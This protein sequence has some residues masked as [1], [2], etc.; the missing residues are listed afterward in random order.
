MVSIFWMPV[1]L[2]AGM[3]FYLSSQP[4]DF[5]HEGPFPHWDK[6]AHGTEY[7][8]FCYLLLRALRGTFPRPVTPALAALAVLIAVA[9]GASDEFHQAFVP[10]RDSDVFDVVADAG[11]ASLVSAVWVLWNKKKPNTT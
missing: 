3:I 10:Y 11:G 5:I 7:G 4:L 2:Y 6:V 1:L 9:Y 8:L